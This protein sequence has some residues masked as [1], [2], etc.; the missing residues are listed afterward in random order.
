VEGET[1]SRRKKRGDKLA[2]M[3]VA[4]L[5]TKDMWVA[6]LIDSCREE[7][8]SIPVVEFF[9]S[10]DEAAEMGRLS[11]K[12]KVHLAR[13]KLRGAAREFY[14]TQSQLKADDV[15]YGEFKNSFIQ[16]FTDK[17][18]DQFHYTRLHNASQER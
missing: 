8:N 14:S 7:S 9:E 3:A 13:L 17:H 11:A 2:D 10:L 5:V 4:P 1:A 12:D 6:N 15:A 16:R 18:A